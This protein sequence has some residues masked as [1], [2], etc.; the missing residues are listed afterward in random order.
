MN[1][2]LRKFMMYHLIHQRDREGFSITKIAGE[3]A[4]TGGQPNVC[5]P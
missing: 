5:F 1:Y 4:S 3:I 2:Y